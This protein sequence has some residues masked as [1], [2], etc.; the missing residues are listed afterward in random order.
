MK[1]LGFRL[2]G[3]H[4]L[5]PRSPPSHPVH[6][7]CFKCSFLSTQPNFFPLQYDNQFLAF[8][9]RSNQTGALYSFPAPL[10]CLPE[11]LSMVSGSNLS[12]WGDLCIVSS[13]WGFMGI[14]PLVC[15]WSPDLY[16]SPALH[17]PPVFSM[18]R[19]ASP[20]VQLS[21]ITSFQ[22]FVCLSSLP[23]IPSSQMS[24]L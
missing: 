15:G 1:G 2:E 7:S 19:V 23:P 6:S 22:Y 24:R 4:L 9:P 14:E 13:L 17:G 8:L 3:S 11:K 12:N 18:L 21:C 5:F 20:D 16:P 10:L